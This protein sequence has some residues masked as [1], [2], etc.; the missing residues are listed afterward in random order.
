[1]NV[2]DRAFLI[3]IAVSLIILLFYRKHSLEVDY[4]LSIPFL[5]IL[6]DSIDS[7]VIPLETNVDLT[8]TFSYKIHDKIADA[9]TYL[10]VYYIFPVEKEF[11]YLVIYR[12]IGVILFGQT[13]D[14]R[15]LMVCP[16]LMKEYMLYHWVYRGDMSGFP[17]IIPVKLVYEIWMH[18]VHS[19]MQESHSNSSSQSPPVS[20]ITGTIAP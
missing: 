19:P 16:D 7:H 11:L 14:V 18:T 8:L 3:R 4:N 13:R 17:V 10:F 20:K 15:W 12:L 1:M 2:F 5:I 6:L 9:L